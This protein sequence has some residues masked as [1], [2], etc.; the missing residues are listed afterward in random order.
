[1][2]KILGIKRV[3][4]IAVLSAI[5]LFMVAILFGLVLPEL[6]KTERDLRVVRASVAN[7]RAELDQL[8]NDFDFFKEQR[9]LFEDLQQ[10]GFFG[11]QDRYEA[12]KRI[13]AIQDQANILHMHYNISPAVVEENKNAAKA[14]Y[15]VLK[16]AATVDVEAMDDLDFY[17]FMYWIDNA[18][19]GQVSI[20]GFDMERVL[21]VNSKT[22]RHIGS[23]AA[24]TLLKGS[25][26]FEWRTLIPRADYMA[27]EGGI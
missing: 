8:K 12:K 25:L 13:E 16:T 5:G 17:S 23:G 10:V 20:T 21:D 9:Y 26:S 24:T 14:D 2:I 3:A 18:F 11:A 15:V 27:E 19:T 1:M 7:G 22:L 6:Q 4:A